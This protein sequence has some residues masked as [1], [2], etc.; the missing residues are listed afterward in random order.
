M[1][2]HAITAAGT[3]GGSLAQLRNEVEKVIKH[4]AAEFKGAPASPTNFLYPIDYAVHKHPRTRAHRCARARM[5]R[6][7]ALPC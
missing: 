7:C 3:L 6:D 5:R 2:A 1:N 4:L